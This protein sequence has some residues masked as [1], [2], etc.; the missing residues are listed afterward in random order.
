MTD[1]K[2]EEMLYKICD[3]ENIANGLAFNLHFSP[4]KL[5]E[6]LCELGDNAYDAGYRKAVEDMREALKP[7][8]G[9]KAVKEA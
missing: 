1:K 7:N 6:V 9:V 4:H 3:R 5:A 2:V 8:T